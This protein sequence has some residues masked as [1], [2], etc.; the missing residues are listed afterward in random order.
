MKRIIFAAL[1][2]FVMIGMSACS[3]DKDLSGTTW[4]GHLQENETMTMGDE[5]ITYAI[6][7]DFVINF[8][9]ETEGTTTITGTMSMDEMTLPVNETTGFTY[10]YDGKGEG[11]ISVKDAESGEVTTERFT[12]DGNVLTLYEG[13]QTMTFNKQ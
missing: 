2:A 6:N 4:K 13:E 1:M 10:T 7:A 8:T 11:T 5:T 12:I 3:K 9:T